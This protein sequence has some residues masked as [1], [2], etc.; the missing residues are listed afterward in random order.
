MLCAEVTGN[1][2]GR[3]MLMI[4]GLLSSNAQWDANRDALGRDLRLVMVELPGHG[5]SAA[6]GAAEAYRADRILTGL[7]AVR[8]DAAVERWWVCGQSLGGAVAVRYCLAHPDRVLGLILTNA[9]A[10]FGVDRPGDDVLPAS[11]R[12]LRLH[13]INATRLPPDVKARLV[14]AADAVPLHVFGHFASQLDAWRSS[15][16]LSRLQVPVL[17]VNGRW[18]TR[19]Q[20]HVAEARAALPQLE[21]VDLEGGHAINA[22]Q[23]G[24]FNAAVVDFVGRH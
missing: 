24:A 19:F 10:V 22:E 11:T 12:D 1:P 15:D 17:L 14:D 3:A 21:V 20:P 16:E 23:P 13:P 6:P 8:R 2:D 9:R 7:E 18:E 4:H 5:R